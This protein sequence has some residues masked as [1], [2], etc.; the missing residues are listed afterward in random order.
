M[1]VDCDT[2]DSGCNG[3]LMA[4]TFSWLKN[5]GCIMFESDYPY[6]GIESTCKSDSSKY[7]I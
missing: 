1:L 4:Y 5:N 6:T 7:A 2:S 3:G